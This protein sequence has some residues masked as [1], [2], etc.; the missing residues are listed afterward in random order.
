MNFQNKRLTGIVLTVAVILLIPLIAE[1][2]W[3]WYDFVFAGV[4]LLGTGLLCE[5]VWRKVKKLEYRIA[6][7]GAIL[8]MLVLIW[9]AIV[10]AE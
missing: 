4:M 5:L 7:C 3:N 1:F 6:L 10:S 9:A 2:P 8:A